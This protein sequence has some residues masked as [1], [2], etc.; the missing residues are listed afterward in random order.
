M[1]NSNGV[2]VLSWL[3]QF[4]LVP[5]QYLTGPEQMALDILLLEQS[6]CDPEPVPVLRLCQS[7]CPWLS[8]G[9][10]QYTWPQHWNYLAVQRS[11]DIVRRPSGGTA[12]LHTG[13]LTYGLI[14]PSAPRSRRRAYQVTCSALAHAY[15]RNGVVLQIGSEPA[16]GFT[17]H[18]FNSAT[19]ADLLDKTGVKRIGSAQFWRRGRLLQHGELL[20]SPDS[21]LWQEVFNEVA[22]KI[23]YPKIQVDTLAKDIAFELARAIDG[24]SSQIC[25]R[26][27]TDVELDWIS[28][29]AELYSLRDE[30]IE[31]LSA[32]P[33]VRSAS[34]MDSTP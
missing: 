28:R 11:L 14:W 32:E 10:H 15:Q 4:R 34:A 26:L 7:K 9:W 33:S 31:R 2:D 19:I 22:P 25:N 3:A 16:G 5:L 12:V 23:T 18:C 6:I 24:N 21:S 8:L 30:C 27:L 1:A 29:K 13:G 20:L 17:P